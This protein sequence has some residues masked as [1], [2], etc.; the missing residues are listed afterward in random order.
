ML[1]ASSIDSSELGK[2]TAS[3]HGWQPAGELGWQPAAE[4]GWQ[5][6]SA[7]V[8]LVTLEL[9]L[10]MTAKILTDTYACNKNRECPVRAEIATYGRAYF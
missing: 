3:E 8:T 9:E 2:Q 10:A 6:V 4:L 5:P 7:V 1:A